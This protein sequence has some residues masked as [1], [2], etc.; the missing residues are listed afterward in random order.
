V[1]DK[2]IYVT[3]CQIAIELTLELDRHLWNDDPRASQWRQEL[4]DHLVVN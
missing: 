4:T 3:K 2:R 1:S